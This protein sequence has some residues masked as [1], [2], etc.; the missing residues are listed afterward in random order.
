[1][2][3]T[4]SRPTSPGSSRPDGMTS[5]PA[6]GLGPRAGA[7]ARPGFPPRPGT[8]GGPGAPGRPSGPGGPDTRLCSVVS[9][10]DFTQ[11]TGA[12]ATQVTPGATADGLTGLPEVY[13]I[14]ADAADPQQLV[15]RGTINYEVAADANTAAS[16]FS[17]VKQSFTGVTDVRH[18]GDAAFTGTPGGTATATGTGLVVV[19]G[20]L[21]LYIS[22]GGDPPTVARLAGQLAT[23]VLSRIA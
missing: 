14:Y 6:G 15:G 7:P 21:L 12:A 23:L 16:V 19:G 8:P 9:P 18:V 11:V 20:R 5:R 4:T 10:A 1:M 2:P 22:V 13:C 3:D 17:K